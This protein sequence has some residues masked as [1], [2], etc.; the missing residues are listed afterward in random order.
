METHTAEEQPRESRDS[1]ES[2]EESGE[3][4]KGG[5]ENNGVF[6]ST[7]GANE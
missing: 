1:S 5:N 7:R 3:G 6:K 4:I 2:E